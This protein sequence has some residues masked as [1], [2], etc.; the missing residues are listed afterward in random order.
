MFELKGAAS[1]RT[2]FQATAAGGLTKLVGRRNELDDLQS[3]LDKAGE[4]R[5]QIFA[6]VAEAGVGKSRLY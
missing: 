1:G 3:T 4:G 5:G 2:R 6:T